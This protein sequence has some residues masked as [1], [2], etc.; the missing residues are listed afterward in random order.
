MQNENMQSVQ[1]LLTNIVD[2][3]IN[4]LS[5]YAQRP[6]SQYITKESKIITVLYKDQ[7]EP[8]CLI[9]EDGYPHLGCF[10]DNQCVRM[11]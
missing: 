10:E 6:K 7:W 3:R 5:R 2:I 4:C 11:T 1:G 8:V 9:V